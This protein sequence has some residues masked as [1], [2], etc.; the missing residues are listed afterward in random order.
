MGQIIQISVVEVHSIIGDTIKP[1]I[2]YFIEKGSSIIGVE[3]NEKE[4]AYIAQNPAPSI[5]WAFCAVGAM[6][7]TD[8]IPGSLDGKGDAMRHC[9]WGACMAKILGTP[10]A[11]LML[12]NHEFG[13]SSNYDAHNN[14]VAL[15]IGSSGALNLWG[16]CIT[17][18]ENG[19]L[20]YAGSPSATSNPPAPS[21]PPTPPARPSSTTTGRG[22]RDHGGSVAAGGGGAGQSGGGGGGGSQG[23]GGGSQ[24]GGGGS[25]GGGGGSQGGGGGSQ[26][27]GGGSQGGGGGSQG[28]GGGSQGGGGG[29]QGGG[30]GSQGG[31]GGS[32]G[33]GSIS[34]GG[35]LA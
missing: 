12:S 19:A 21:A 15:R 34:G 3:L 9:L 6:L 31:G 11:S 22:G 20:Q 32:Q 29:S 35:G 4:K 24:G 1:I 26:G 7:S 2:D 27:G 14:E 8:H 28:G 16:A 17:A 5:G 30:G 33:G 13:Q 18:A 23:G 10:T 25:Q